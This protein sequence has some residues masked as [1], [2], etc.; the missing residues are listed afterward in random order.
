MVNSGSIHHS[1]KY[2][3][4]IDLEHSLQITATFEYYVR[5]ILPEMSSASTIEF[6]EDM[7]KLLDAGA[8][9]LEDYDAVKRECKEETGYD[10]TDIKFKGICEEICDNEDTKIYYKQY[11]HKLYHIFTCT[12]ASENVNQPTETDEMQISC[13]WVDRNK[14]ENLRIL[15]TMIQEN[16]KK[17][18]EDDKPIDMGSIHIP[19][20]HG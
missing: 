20:N 13:E 9:T 14:N 7:K 18:I 11:A 6:I 5:T 17:L 2:R 3:N 15:P 1:Y 4:L 19:Y 12:L 10:V 16:I 8:I